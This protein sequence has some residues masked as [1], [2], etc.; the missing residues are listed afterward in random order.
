[1]GVLFVM[2]DV[3]LFCLTSQVGVVRVKAQ[4][5]T[6]S[7]AGIHLISDNLPIP[8]NMH[9]PMVMVVLL[10]FSLVTDMRFL[11]LKFCGVIRCEDVLKMVSA[12]LWQ[13]VSFLLLDS[14]KK[15]CWS[16]VSLLLSVELFCFSLTL[17]C[18]S[19]VVFV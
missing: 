5:K 9:L 19:S 3:N 4:N 14:V 11:P 15:I 12:E 17:V 7:A 18:G 2:F 10:T 1:M 6:G 16:Q 8:L 13:S